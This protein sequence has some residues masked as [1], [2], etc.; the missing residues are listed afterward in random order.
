MEVPC[1]GGM[2]EAVKTAI[3]NSG[4][5]IPWRRV[6]LTEEQYLKILNKLKEYHSRLLKYY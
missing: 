6:T 4:K 3:L 5:L 2:V 1:C